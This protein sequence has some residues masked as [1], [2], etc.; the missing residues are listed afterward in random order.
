MC[1]DK[2]MLS[3]LLDDESR[4]E[5]RQKWYYAE[6]LSQQHGT[7]SDYSPACH[8]CIMYNKSLAVKVHPSISVIVWMKTVTHRQLKSYDSNLKTNVN[9]P[10]WQVQGKKKRWVSSVWSTA[11]AGVDIWWSHL[12]HEGLS[13]ALHELIMSSVMCAKQRPSKTQKLKTVAV[14][15]VFQQCSW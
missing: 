5:C 8:Y 6:C 4:K 15:I 14:T 9:K 1:R 11:K 7:D 3:T 12:M 10:W 13:A 2:M